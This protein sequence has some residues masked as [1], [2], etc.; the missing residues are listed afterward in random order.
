M[1]ACPNPQPK[2]A[3]SPR[4][5]IKTKAPPRVKCTY[6]SCNF[7]FQTDKDMKKHKTA[8]SEHEYCNK[9]DIEFEMEEH[10]LLHKIKSNKHI[11][12]PICGIDFDSEGGRD[13]HIRQLP[14]ARS[15]LNREAIPNQPDRI[16]ANTNGLVDRHWPRLTETGLENRMSDL[17]DVSTPTGNGKEN[18]KL[19]ASKASASVSAAGAGAES[20]F[21]SGTLAASA[22]GSPLFVG[23]SNAGVELARIYKD[24]NPGNFIDVFTGEYVCA[25]GKRCLTKEAFET[26]VLA[27]SQG[28]RRM[29]C[30]N[31]LKIFKSTAAII[32][33]W[34]SPSLKCDQS[35]ADMYAQIVDEVSGGLIHI[36]GYNEDGTISGLTRESSGLTHSSSGSWCSAESTY[37]SQAQPALRAMES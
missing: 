24:W 27:E 19:P 32:T 8:S 18:E 13:R 25:C 22:L 21:K 4:N 37:R 7:R 11:V 33:H 28:A 1:P 15:D 26:H 17:M 2:T 10:L 5:K 12:C 23:I 34:E 35:E 36:A 16:T 14:M 3:A 31:C 9:C 30:P 20:K 6:L 29:Q